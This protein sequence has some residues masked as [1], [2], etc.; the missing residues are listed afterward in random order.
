[1]ITTF[2]KFADEQ[3]AI[4]NLPR[5]RKPSHA[6]EIQW[7]THDDGED[8]DRIGTIYK[9]TGNYIETEMGSMPEMAPIDGYH[10]NMIGR[11]LD[12]ALEP[13]VVI[14]TNPSRVFA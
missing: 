2:L 13:F 12:A 5:F 4:D 1:M 9:P 8:I 6:G 11:T 14:P 7:V 10:V 3:E